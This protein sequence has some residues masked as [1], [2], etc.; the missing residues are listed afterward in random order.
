LTAYRGLKSK[1]IEE[2]SDDTQ[3]SDR[4]MGARTFDEIVVALGANYREWLLAAAQAASGLR[5]AATAS[6]EAA[7]RAAAAREQAL[8]EV[9]SFFERDRAATTDVEVRRTGPRQLRVVRRQHV[10]SATTAA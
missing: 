4:I 2:F 9:M 7:D 5:S 8:L 6:V 1:L 3:L 10:H